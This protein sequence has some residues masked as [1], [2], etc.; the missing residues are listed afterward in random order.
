MNLFIG[1]AA[2]MLALALG[3]LGWP[4]WRARR[5]DGRLGLGLVIA[6][7]IALPVGA[8]LLYRSQSNWSWD[9]KEM[10]DAYAGH[11]SIEGMV[12]KLEE[13]L[14][15]NPDDVDSWLMLGRTR[16][17]LKNI[18]GAVD[19]FSSAYKA[20]NGQNVEAI[21]DY[22]EVLVMS[23]SSTLM[24]KA[25][26]LFEDALKL[27]PNNV[28]ALYYGG[29]EAAAKGKP[30]VTRERFAKLLGYPLPDQVRSMLA[31]RIGELDKQLGRP[32]DPEIAKV[33]ATAAAPVAMP[34]STPA[35]ATATAPAAST[36]SG[37]S[38]A[39]ASGPGTVTV[40]VS[41]SPAFASKVPAGTPLFVLARD[42]SQPGPPFAAKRF[43]SVALPI[44]ITL[45]EADAMMPGRTIKDAHS[46]TIVA[47]YSAS[48]RPMAS[49]GDIYGEVAYD[50]A[51]GARTDLVID[52]QV[53]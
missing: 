5:A 4:L 13:R 6:L 14:R 7:A 20:S 41:M 33:A 15:K 3:L 17:V 52:K 28:K 53:P 32:V 42:P 25:G 29:E 8:T 51:K 34:A 22:A 47:R 27:D 38:A 9:P 1:L 43:T 37:P 21:V 36:A 11:Q 10:A 46:L 48:G 2:L 19:A 31:A 49:S 39:A 40:H 44:D 26:D 23:D 16:F 35:T 24:G 30:S 18:P 45:T 12:A 50:L